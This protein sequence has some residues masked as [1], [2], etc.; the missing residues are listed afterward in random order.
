MSEDGHEVFLP[1]GF[2]NAGLVRRVGDS[3]RRP[4]RPASPAA[5]ALLDHLAD[6]GFEGAPRFL[7]IDGRGREMLSFIPGEAAI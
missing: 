2:T 1:G 5:R 4:W 7:G 3:V 6:V